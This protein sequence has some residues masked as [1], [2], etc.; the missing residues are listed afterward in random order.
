VR[1]VAHPHRCRRRGRTST[2]SRFLEHAEHGMIGELEVTA[3]T[4]MVSVTG[5]DRD[6]AI[7]R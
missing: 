5:D 1:P 7:P 2:Q 4:V 3:L 6:H